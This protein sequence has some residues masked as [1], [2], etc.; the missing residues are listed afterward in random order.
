M[1]TARLI[2]SGKDAGSHGVLVIFIGATP[3]VV[4]DVTARPT[5]VADRGTFQ[6]QISCGLS[7]WGDLEMPCDAS[8]EQ[9][10]APLRFGYEKSWWT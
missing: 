7:S 9:M 4:M 6:L 1:P 2:A 8:A 10:F 3:T 5:G